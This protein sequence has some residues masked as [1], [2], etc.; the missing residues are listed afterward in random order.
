MIEWAIGWPEGVQILLEFGAD[1]RQT[2]DML[3]LLYPGKG[4]Q[5]SAEILLKAGCPIHPTYLQTRFEFTGGKEKMIL[6]IRCF[7]ERFLPLDLIPV[8]GENQLLDGSNCRQVLEL[9]ADHKVPLPHPFTP[10]AEKFLGLQGDMTVYHG[11]WSKLCA[12]ALYQVGFLDTDRLDSNSY[13]PLESLGSNKLWDVLERLTEIIYWH[14]SKGA[15]LH[16][17]LAWASE[18]V[19]HVLILAM[20][21]RSCYSDWI[22]ES[23]QLAEVERYLRELVAMGDEFFAPTGVPDGCSCPC[24]P[25]G[26]TAVSAILRKLTSGSWRW[27]FKCYSKCQRRVFNFVHEWDQSYWE[28]PQEVIRSLTFNA[29]GLTHTCFASIHKGQVLCQP[30][31]KLLPEYWYRR[32]KDHLLTRHPDNEEHVKGAT[33]VGVELEFCGLSVPDWMKNCIARKVEEVNDEDAVD[34]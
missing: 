33:S 2:Y 19:S 24:S 12:E 8:S 29:L 13:S 15:N 1:P 34:V 21:E 27:H 18:S 26:C 10:N 16:R 7:A 5:S 20:I 9:L 3:F 23:L 6:L 28:K 11:K 30:L 17:T 32:V 22:G 14:I 31:K 4:R 25:G